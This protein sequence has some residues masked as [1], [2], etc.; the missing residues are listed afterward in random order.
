MLNNTKCMYLLMLITVCYC[1]ITSYKFIKKQNMQ[2]SK[3]S[4]IKACEKVGG[5]TSIGLNN[6]ENS[7]YWHIV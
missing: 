3:T 5:I 7:L 6:N 1:P 4:S 2:P